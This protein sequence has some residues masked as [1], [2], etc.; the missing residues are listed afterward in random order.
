MKIEKMDDGVTTN[1]Y[2]YQN[3]LVCAMADGAESMLETYTDGADWFGRVRS[4]AISGV[5]E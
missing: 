2:H 4:G 3:W 1:V 5:C